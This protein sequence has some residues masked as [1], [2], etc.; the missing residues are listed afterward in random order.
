MLNGQDKHHNIDQLMKMF[1]KYRNKNT[2]KSMVMDIF[3]NNKQQ[4]EAYKI[5]SAFYLFFSGQ[6]EEVLIDKKSVIEYLK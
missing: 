1:S 3:E 4:Y 2:N 6:T 5:F